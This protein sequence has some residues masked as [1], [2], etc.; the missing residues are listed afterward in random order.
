MRHV[1]QLFW[2]NGKNVVI[3]FLKGVYMV[4]VEVGF[5][6]ALHFVESTVVGDGHLTNELGLSSVKLLGGEFRLSQAAQL[7]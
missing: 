5:A 7:V 4:E 2:G 3:H 6:D 1:L